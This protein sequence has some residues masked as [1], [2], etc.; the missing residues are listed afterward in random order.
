MLRHA[1]MSQKPSDRTLIVR[2]RVQALWRPVILPA[3]T[4]WFIAAFVTSAVLRSGDLGEYQRY[5]HAFVQA[6]LFHHF[7]LEYPAPALVVFALPLLL[8]LAYPWA[9]AVLVGVVLVAL[10]IS[11]ATAGVPSMDED[12]ARRLIVYLAL[13]TAMVL[14][15]RY[16]IFAA[17]AAFW[18]LRAAR[19]DRWSAAWTWSCVGCLLKLFPAALWPVLFVGEWRSSGRIPW[20]RSL[21]VV[22]SVFVLAGIPE[23]LNPAG[24]LNAFHYYLH[25]PSEIGSL[26][27]GLS[28]IFDWRHWTYVNSFH[29]VNVVSPIV[30][31]LT[32]TFGMLAAVGCVVVWWAQARRRLTLEEACLAT[33]TLVVLGMKV[34][35]TQYLIW[36]IPFWAIYRLRTSWIL[37]CALNTALFPFVVAATGIGFVSSQGLAIAMTLLNFGRD[38]LIGVGTV[39]WAVE[40]L[41]G[42]SPSSEGISPEQAGAEAL[43]EPGLV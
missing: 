9:F 30:G 4:L 32:S 18:A 20:R 39:L 7:P 6:P 22:C 33:L 15:D 34:L 16:D 24:S 37:A 11:Y 40:L 31:P 23:L 13:G 43:A 17:A 14:T 41:R 28:L 38:L 27:A 3:V 19:R 21:W 12:A 29:T 25:R 8:P 2:V 26:P 35:S 1:S 42:R 5:A 36:L 10:S